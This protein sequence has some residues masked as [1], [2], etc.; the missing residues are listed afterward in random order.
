MSQSESQVE[1][2]R[3]ALAREDAPRLTIY[4]VA[5]LIT[6]IVALV[7]AGLVF[8]A[9]HEMPGVAEEARLE[10]AL[11]PGAA[12]FEQYRRQLP[13]SN[14]AATEAP[15]ALGDVVMELTALVR[16]ETGRAVNGLELRGA[17]VD[18]QGAVI[19][20]R[21]VAVIPAQQSV[22]EPDE[23]MSVRL[24]LEGISPQAERAGVRLEVVGLRFE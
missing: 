21:A 2:K 17:V 9:L 12:E 3:G 15:R 7:T 24:L 16:N 11:R 19:R 10:G 13:L 23:T 20:E 14:L 8:W 6:L 18:S 4:L 22:L 1:R 5:G